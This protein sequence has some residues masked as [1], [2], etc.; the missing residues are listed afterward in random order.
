MPSIRKFAIFVFLINCHTFLNAQKLEYRS[1]LLQ[2]FERIESEFDCNFSF[3]DQDISNHFSNNPTYGNLEDV[4]DFLRKTTLFEY[5]I[6]PDKTITVRHKELLDSFCVK[7]LNANT[8]LPFQNVLV[9]TP[10]QEIASDSDG[11]A[12][13]MLLSKRDLITISFV[14]FE[15]ISEPASAYQST[16]CETIILQPKI[17]F[18]NTI[19]LSNYIAK[20]ISKSA[21]GALTIDY[22]KFDILPGLIEPDVLQTIQALPGIQSV[23]ETV[24]FINIRGGT[25]DQN[26]ILWDGIKMYQSGH[27]FGLISAFNPHLTQKVTVQ[28]NG[29]SAQYGDGVSGLVDMRSETALN[30]RL[31]V[32]GGVNLISADGYIDVPIGDKASLLIAGRRSINGVYESPT[33][34]SYFEKAFQNTEVLSNSDTQ[35]NSDDAF[36]FFDASARLLYQPSEKD[37][38]RANFLLVGNQLEFLENAEVDGILQQRKSDLGQDN[39]SAG[40]FYERQWSD[41]WFSQLQLYGSSYKLEATNF[42][43]IN[44]Q[45]LLQQNN[46]FETGLRISVAHQFN[47]K[48]NANFGYQLNETGVTNFEQLNNPFFQ[49][50]DKQVIITQSVFSEVNLKPFSE[51]TTIQAGLRINHIG[52]FDEVLVEPRLSF[53]QRFL[54]HFTIEI[55]GELKSQTTSQIIDFQNDFLGVENR[56]WVLSRPDDIP[57]LKGRQISLGINYNR[58]G[59]L[60]SAE[61]YVKKI[62]GITSQS[63]GFQNQFQNTRVH[64][65]YTVRGIDLLINKRFKNINTWL[66]YSY[67]DNTYR[68]DEFT[69]QE[70]Q[71]NIDIRHTLT[72]GISYSF[73]N[74][75]LSGGLNWHTGKPT[76]RPV[77]R[78]PIVDNEVNFGAP[79]QFNIEDYFRV[80]TSA[81]YEFQLA[82]KW[83]AYIGVSIWNLLNTENVLNNFYRVNVSDN[84]EEI[85]ERSLE[86]TPNVTFRVKF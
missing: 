63:Q 80:D 52:K 53:S 79:N 15:T 61:P 18:L 85:N 51:N 67:A 12:T 33:Y 47:P 76:T 34:N 58:F 16:S 57:I 86:F 27:F 9:R 64:G 56:R 69:P 42:D 70:F 25:N 62:K 74:F 30:D 45:R 36:S 2:I 19:R 10:Y 23:N 75:K 59:W 32:G 66:S 41:D 31:K 11:L 71:N 28:K 39:V 65:S 1:P 3:K 24:S 82:K 6:L 44:D 73:E 43:V 20:G 50:N 26:L 5:Q 22:E 13:G 21:N 4:I 46:V 40:L 35:T 48:L 81:T 38:I 84:I 72:S 68:F 14:G 54:S 55:Q 8:G 17:E 78:E 60:V 83:K 49:R 77:E 7:L 29:V 37:K